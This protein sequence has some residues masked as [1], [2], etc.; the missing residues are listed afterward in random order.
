MILKFIDSGSG[1]T[2]LPLILI[3]GMGSASSAWQTVVPE[4][5]KTSRVITVD[6]PG[7]GATKLPAGLDMSPKALAEYVFETMD[8]LEIEKANLIGN[9]LGGWTALEMAA[10]KPDR[11]ASVLGL[12]PAGLWLAPF[13]VRYPGTAIARNLASSL[14][15]VSPF[16][17]KYEWGRKIGFSDVSPQW[18]KFSY[19]LCL[20]ATLSLANSTGYF[21]AWDA[22]LHRRFDSEVSAQVPVTIVFGDS[23]K[24]LPENSC[25]EKT[26][27]P[28]HTNWLNWESCG[29][30]PMWDYPERVISEIA[31]LTK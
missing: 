13:T 5:V 25:Q 1:N 15:V 12:A 3:H 21:P 24:T 8:S 28:K 2:G 16:G 30:A 18:K 10:A 9:S 14:K 7:H 19:Q 17:L 4:L 22:L 6:L 29:H 11:V 31:K 23:D 20:D 27:A 26:L